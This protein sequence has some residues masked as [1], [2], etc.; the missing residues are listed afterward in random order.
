MT[1]HVGLDFGASNTRVAST[2]GKSTPVCFC[3]P[4][5]HNTLIPTQ[6]GISGANATFL[7][8]FAIR[9]KRIVRR[10]KEALMGDA[11][12]T[13]ESSSAFVQG[14]IK[15][16]VASEG[17]ISTLVAT[18][19]DAWSAGSYQAA[20]EKLSSILRRHGCSR[21]RFVTEPDAAACYYIYHISRER[22]RPFQGTAIV[23]DGGGSTIDFSVLNVSDGQVERIA[24]GGIPD[25]LTDPQHPLGYAGHLF[26]TMV[27]ERV[28]A[29]EP[30]LATELSNAADNRDKL[31]RIFAELKDSTNVENGEKHSAKTHSAHLFSVEDYDVRLEDF[32]AVFDKVFR[33]RIL[34]ELQ[35]VL[36]AAQQRQKFN[37]ADPETCRI[38][39]VGG[40]SELFLTRELIGNYFRDKFGRNLDPSELLTQRDRLHAS[41]LGACLIASQQI[42]L[43]E[44]SPFTFGIY[45][46][47]E[48]GAQQ[49]YPLISQGEPLGRF[50]NFIEQVPPFGLAEIRHEQQTS[51]E[52]YLDRG[53]GPIPLPMSTAFEK[54]LPDIT[55][56][57]KWRVSLSVVDGIT[58]VRFQTTTGGGHRSRT[59]SF[60]MGNLFS[61]AEP[62]RDTPEIDD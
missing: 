37:I 11:S 38:V 55:P 8:P 35:Q 25:G 42:L 29:R 61:L 7:G 57:Q 16:F 34:I 31:L 54:A 40:F 15:Q 14:I 49:P 21:V 27:M 39:L 43:N 26:D 59:K 53:H 10:L 4:G 3:L 32:T 2:R 9:A 17:A 18:I 23:V 56:Q 60:R 22:G 12:E 28:A 45:L 6:L 30:L 46:W 48:H 52:F 47:D 5:T 50:S 44:V 13:T 51:V 20:Q 36:E 19:P 33:P 1:N 41:A 62:W 58:K 24:S